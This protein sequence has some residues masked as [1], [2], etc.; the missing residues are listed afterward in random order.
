MAVLLLLLRAVP[1]QRPVWAAGRHRGVVERVVVCVPVAQLCRGTHRGVTVGVRALSR[2]TG[3]TPALRGVLRGEEL[4]G[5]AV[6][7]VPGLRSGFR[8]EA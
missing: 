2:V 8:R 1:P 3:L 5:R 7:T 4:Q 6:R